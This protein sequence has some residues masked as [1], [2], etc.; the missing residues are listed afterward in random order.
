MSYFG[1]L[2]RARDDATLKRAAL[3]SDR[4]ICELS[5]DAPIAT[6]MGLV[7]AVLPDI[8]QIS[9]SALSASDGDRS[10]AILALFDLMKKGADQDATLRSDLATARSCYE[11]SFT[12]VEQ[13]VAQ[14][15][16]VLARLHADTIRTVINST[17]DAD[18]HV[19]VSIVSD[20]ATPDHNIT[21]RGVVIAVILRHF[22]LPAEDTPWEAIR[23]CA[24][25]RKLDESLRCFGRGSVEWRANGSVQ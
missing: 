18:Q 10:R 6:D 16:D 17:D 13:S 8:R 20:T 1:V 2:W 15:Q 3:L 12:A 19:V 11:D 24:M 9:T 5:S 22:P 7:R 14:W 21:A 23:D 25:T 4:L